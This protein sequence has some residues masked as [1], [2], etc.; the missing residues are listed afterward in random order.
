MSTPTEAHKELLREI[1]SELAHGAGP[2]ALQL[3]ADSEARAVEAANKRLGAQMGYVVALQRAIEYHAQGLVIPAAIGSDCPHHASMLNAALTALRER[4]RV[5]EEACAHVRRAEKAEA[6]NERLKELGD[7]WAI[8]ARNEADRA[9]RAEVESAGRLKVLE[10]KA[11]ELRAE[12]L[13]AE[14][15]EAALAAARKDSERFNLLATLLEDVN[16]GDIDPT[17]HRTEDNEWPDAWRN[18]IDAAMTNSNHKTT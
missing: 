15:A 17:K 3:L 4:V 1:R 2:K 5:L 14:R 18:A 16:M 11:E 8:D 12:W 10:E 7:K 9:E 13:R 6:A